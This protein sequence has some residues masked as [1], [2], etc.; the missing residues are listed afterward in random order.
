MSTATGTLMIMAGGTGGHVMPGLAVAHEMR[1]R[2]WNVV[3]LGV[4]GSMEADLVPR[5][6]I[7]M[8][9]VRFGGLRGKNLLTRLL[10][11]LNLL[12]A[13]WQSIRALRAAKPSVVLG[14]GG[15]VAFP[16][17]MMAVLLNKPLVVH[18]QNSVAGLTNRVLAQIA[19]RVLEAFPGSLK[20]AQ[21][22]G[23]PLRAAFAAQQD[24]AARYAAR[25]GPLNIL[26]VGGSLGASILNEVVPQAMAQIDPAQRPVVTH[27]SGKAHKQT[28]RDNYAQAGVDANIIDFIDDMAAACEQADLVICRAGAMTVAEIAAIGVAAILVPFPYAVDDHQTANARYLSDADAAILLPQPELN[29]AQLA[30]TISRLDRGSLADMAGRARA[31]ARPDATREVADA[32]ESV[33][34]LPHGDKS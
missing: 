12:R 7:A 26:V 4:P 31:L 33:A 10:L 24:P 34:R 8:H 27:Q 18:E 28:L 9:W 29:A 23:N 11:P 14:M 13:F 15:Y 22:T 5:H 1:S 3:W 16:G 19:D 25:T 6:N 21:C 17:G 2:N 30:Q 20:G 32:C